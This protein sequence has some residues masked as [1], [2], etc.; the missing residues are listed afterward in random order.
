MTLH[1]S[2]RRFIDSLTSSGPQAGDADVDVARLR[3][4]RAE[5]VPIDAPDIA[6]V[7]DLAVPGPAGEVPVRHYH[8]APAGPALPCVVY[9]HGGGY[10]VGDLETHDHIARLLAAE[11]GATVVAVDYRLA[12]EHRFPAA[13]DDAF[14]ATRWVADN[15]AE[16]GA[17]PARLA[18][19]GDS[20]GGG[21]AAA[22]ALMTRD[23][24]GPEIAFQALVYPV[25][26]L[27]GYPVAGDTPY[28]SRVSNGEGYF[29]TSEGMRWFAEQYL[30]EPGEGSDF[31]A[32]P[33]RAADLA[34]LPPALVVTA[35]FDP[36]RDEGE[37]YARA[38]AAA[39]VP[40]TTTRVN[41]G[42]HG[43]FGLGALLPVCRQA[44]EPVVAALRS[45]LGL[46]RPVG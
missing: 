22:V 26:D 24:G 27:S 46:T 31:R 6:L 30:N 33:I 35:D 15:A 16:L 25:T 43:M 1:P 20:A 37:D 8:P 10:V 28:G 41:G 13:V 44:E 39:G 3:A 2:T 9:F 18:V 23:G 7:R 14:A 11:T 42:F 17:D 34:G 4:A 19:A 32:S 12:P 21:L 45:A 38:L 36:L 40:A 29:L 5:R